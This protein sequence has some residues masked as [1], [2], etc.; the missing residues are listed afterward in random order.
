M[1]TLTLA[2]G[3]LLP[4]AAGT[5]CLYPLRTRLRLDC[6]GTLGYGYFLGAALLYLI[7][8]LVN[9]SPGQPAHLPVALALL[10]LAV[11]GLW[12]ARRGG[13]TGAQI[14]RTAAE[15]APPGEL[16]WLTWLVSGLLAV[17][18]VFIAIELLYRPV[19]PWDAWQ[20]W[21]YKAKVW[22]YAGGLVPLDTPADWLGGASG[23]IYNTQ[24]AHYPGLLPAQA[25]WAALANG[26]WSETRVN[27]PTFLCGLALCLA[28]WSQVLASTRSRLIAACAVYGLISLPIV[29]THLSLAGYA[30]IWLAGFSGLGLVALL[31]GMLEGLTGQA[32]LGAGFLALG[33]LTKFDALIWL[34][35]GLALYGVIFHGRA[36]VIALG[37]A[38][39]I[40]AGL[41]IVDITTLTLPVLGSVG[42]DGST[43]LLG[44]LGAWPLTLNNVAPAYVKHLY[45]MGSWNLLWYLAPLVVIASLLSPS[46]GKLRSVLAGFFLIL[47]ASQAIV[48]GFTVAGAWAEDG[49]SLNRVLLQSTPAVVFLLAVALRKTR[50]TSSAVTAALHPV[51]AA[52]LPVAALLIVLGSTGLWLQQQ[53]KGSQHEARN[54]SPQALRAVMGASS[55][56]DGRAV[57]TRYQNG[58]AILSTGT[59]A[60][61]AGEFRMAKID[62]Q[63]SPLDPPTFF[64]RS[65]SDPQNLHTR[66]LAPDED[67]INLGN[68][69]EWRGRI[70]EAGVVFFQDPDHQSSLNT[71]S[72]L[73]DTPT[74]LARLALHQWLE[75]E[76]WTQASINA[77][78]GGAKSPLIPLPLLLGSWLVLCTL[79][80]ALAR[81]RI[82]A[83]SALAVAII[84]MAWGLADLRW[85]QSL[86]GQSRDTTGHYSKTAALD[87]GEDE[88]IQQ[89]SRS[90]AEF[91]GPEL[92]RIVIGMQPEG[93]LRFEARRAKYA[94][95]PHA[96]HVHDGDWRS[97]P[98]TQM[99]ALLLLRYPDDPE[100]RSLPR[101]IRVDDQVF[102][103]AWSSP[104]GVLYRPART[105]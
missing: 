98:A 39:M 104:H 51:K 6:A 15:P 3:L 32:A 89:L 5:A 105:R 78:P 45:L 26:A 86:H 103:P 35:C 25:Y 73:P 58:S 97:L 57:I 82:R 20:T 94:L 65:A 10:G 14:P 87:I 41:A 34:A 83:P 13:A 63:H 44:P 7:L 67:L 60:L 80:L 1:N 40:L 46:S 76:R 64:W 75:Q 50:L 71:L 70:T 28:L 72:L 11:A 30:D 96:A 43:L 17:H 100:A 31:R 48:F 36:V 85:L 12:A 4:W 59:I 95:L 27:W 47:A 79:L 38:A 93:A 74:N 37:A 61:D 54:F 91:L 88:A 53:A 2:A 55:L 92:R 66:P 102:M 23:Q 56:V 21:M 22:H 81:S 42:L 29:H 49:T 90:V 52:A 33:L 77:I 18:V 24:G 19:F 101:A 99:D 69:P 84:L 68:D 62:T 9:N 8:L 16:Q